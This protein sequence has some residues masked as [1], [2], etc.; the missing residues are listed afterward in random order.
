M[1]MPADEQIDAMFATAERLREE[2]DAAIQNKDIAAQ[3]LL[4]AKLA[5]L[6]LSLSA[7][8]T[9]NSMILRTIMTPLPED[10]TREERVKSL[11]ATFRH[12]A[13]I[14]STAQNSPAD[15]KL[16]AAAGKHLETILNGLDAIEPEGRRALVPFLDSY[17]PDIRAGAAIALLDLMPE[18]ALAVLRDL[19]ENAA[20][21]NGGLTAA[22]ALKRRRDHVK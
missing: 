7:R 3:N 22:V 11:V 19:D 1:T 2:L 12:V 20:G 16:H 17:N 13:W 4:A 21:T 5:H 6:Q 15:E 18:R 9:A 14:R 10:C 8:E